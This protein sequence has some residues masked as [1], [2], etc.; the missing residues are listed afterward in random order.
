MKKLAENWRWI[1]REFRE[2]S[3]INAYWANKLGS[4]WF[5]TPITVTFAK[6]VI[7]FGRERNVILIKLIITFIQ[8]NHVIHSSKFLLI[9]QGKVG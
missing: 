9:Q 6:T 3:A 7:E 5:E 1:S 8:C 4:I 2:L